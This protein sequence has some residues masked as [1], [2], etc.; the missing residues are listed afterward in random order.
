MGEIIVEL[1]KIG[2]GGICRLVIVEGGI[3]GG[4][5]VIIEGM[6]SKVGGKNVERIRGSVEIEMRGKEGNMLMLWDGMY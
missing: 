4:W 5:G 3:M 1:M 6:I 2:G